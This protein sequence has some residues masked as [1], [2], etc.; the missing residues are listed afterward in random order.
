MSFMLPKT[1]LILGGAKSVFKD[2]ERALELFKPDVVIGV[3]DIVAEVPEITHFCTMH[4]KKA[5]KWIEERRKNGF[6]D[7]VK[8]WT[9]TD[10]SAPPGFTFEQIP[11]TR[12]GSG[13]LAIYVARY[14]KYDKKILAGIPMTR[15]GQHFF[16][17]SDWNE[18]KL[19][20]VVWEKNPTLREDVRSMSGWTMETFG[21]PTQE[22]LEF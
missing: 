5:P 18:C 11:N 9:S 6:P 3:N 4:P 10:K 2:Y 20:R 7:P 13:L 8:Y 12:G 14:L 1:A 22:W 21:F 16:I 19:Y 15:E 17:Q